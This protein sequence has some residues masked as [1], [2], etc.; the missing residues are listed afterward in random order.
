M[1]FA[2][3]QT[4]ARYALVM[5]YTGMFLVQAIA[6]KKRQEVEINFVSGATFLIAEIGLWLLATV[7][8]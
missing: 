6:H 8:I 1:D 4:I 3:I 7:R 5:W 2:T